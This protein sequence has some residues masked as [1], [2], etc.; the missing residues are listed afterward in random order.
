[1]KELIKFKHYFIVLGAILFATYITDPLWNLY[2]QQSESLAL[3]NARIDKVSSLL[4]NKSQL[5]DALGVLE[6]QTEQVSELVFTQATEGEYK[7]TVQ[8]AIENI[9]TESNCKLNILNWS[10][11]TQILEGMSAKVV[12]IELSGGPLCI[13][14]SMRLLEAHKPII[15]IEKY[16][17]GA[18]GWFGRISENLEVEISVK[19]WRKATL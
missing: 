19:T 1:M 13:A 3:S 16:A 8:K 4:D 6:A 9:L 14:K 2:L 10:D 15:R 12:D 18:R 5:I 17:F 7:L 11:A